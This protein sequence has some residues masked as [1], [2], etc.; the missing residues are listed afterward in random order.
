MGT[1]PLIFAGFL[2]QLISSGQSRQEIRLMLYELA[3]AF[4]QRIFQ[5]K[6]L[7]GL[8]IVGLLSIFVGGF[9]T[10]TDKIKAGPRE[11]RQTSSASPA[12]GQGSAGPGPA[13]QQQGGKEGQA[14][15]PQPR[16]GQ[17]Q[18]AKIA[19]LEPQVATQFVSWW[20]GQS[21]DFNPQTAAKNRQQ[22]AGWIKPEVVPMYQAAFWPPE[23]ADGIVSGRLRGSYTP[24]SVQ[25]LAQNPDGSIVVQ[26]NGQLVLQQGP[27]P[28][29]QQ[30]S[31]DYLVKREKEGLRIAGLYNRTMVLPSSSIY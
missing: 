1:S 16:Q 3:R 9:G 23:V 15:Q 11:A 26:V 6:I 7:A 10:A 4:V 24:V 30:L 17:S 14:S 22:A 21:M 31:T 12:L 19:V 28:A 2:T 25:A 27:R 20:M 29:V 5:D 18:Q 8:V 13:S